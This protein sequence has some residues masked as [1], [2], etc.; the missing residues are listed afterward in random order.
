MTSYESIQ[1]FAARAESELT[2]LDI[3]ILNAG[4][5]A[6]DHKLVTGTGHERVIQVN[7]LSTFLLAILM[8]PI[9]KDKAF[10]GRPG[11]MTIVGSG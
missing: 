8:L 7:Y 4:M 10:G 6:V 5:T 9:A 3:S 11:R 2:R 1:A